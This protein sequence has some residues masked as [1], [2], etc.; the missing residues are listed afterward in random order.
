MFLSVC[1]PPFFLALFVLASPSILKTD[2][3]FTTN[4]VSPSAG[5]GFG[6]T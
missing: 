1:A 3:Y 5:A 6:R 2:R 4:M